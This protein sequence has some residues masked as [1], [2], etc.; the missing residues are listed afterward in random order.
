MSEYFVVAV[1]V[2]DDD[3][4]LLCCIMYHRKQWSAAS[5]IAQSHLAGSHTNHSKVK[6][7]HPVL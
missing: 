2:D 7:L 4:M 6:K 1:E 5:F 3:A